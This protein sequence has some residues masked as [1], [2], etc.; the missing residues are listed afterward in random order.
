ME[1]SSQSHSCCCFTA[2]E[3]P[4]IP[5]P[6]PSTL[7]PDSGPRLWDAGNDCCVRLSN[8]RG[9]GTLMFHLLG[10]NPA[11]TFC[12]ARRV[13]A[14][15]KPPNWSFQASRYWEGHFHL[16]CCH[17]IHT[18]MESLGSPETALQ[19]TKAAKARKGGGASMLCLA[20]SGAVSSRTDS[21]LSPP[22]P[23]PQ[24][25]LV[26]LLWLSAPSVSSGAEPLGP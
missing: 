15:L 18:W 24:L 3:P 25:A 2:H 19:A 16:T 13:E 14:S 4:R 22:A 7:P 21:L 1:A 11:S 5:I 20:H 10:S 9:G 23:C 12:E 6:D 26:V 17:P 8:P